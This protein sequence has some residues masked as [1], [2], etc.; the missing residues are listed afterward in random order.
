MKKQLLRNIVYLTLFLIFQASVTFSQTDFY[1]SRGE[2]VQ[3]T[4]SAEAVVIKFKEDITANEINTFLSAEDAI[5]D[6]N[7]LTLAGAK[8][9]F[10]ATLKSQTNLNQLS[11]R[12][13]G[14]TEVIALNNVYYIEGLEAVPYDQFMVQ[15]KSSVNRSQV[16][17][18]NKQ[19]DV[20][21]IE[22]NISVDHLYRLRVT[23][24]SDLSVVDMAK[25]YHESLPSE[26]STPDFIVP[27]QLY[28]PNDPYFSNQYYL[29]NTGQ[30][31]GVTDADIDALEAWNITIGSSS[32]TVAVIDEGGSSHPDLPASRLVAGYDYFY[33]DSD[34]SAGGN[35]AHSMASAGVVAGT[36][37]NS[38]GITGVA[39][40]SKVMHIRI[41]DECGNGASISNI[42]NSIDFAWQNGADIISNSW[43]Y[44]SSNPNFLP[45]IVDAINRALTMGR[46]DGDLIAEPSDK[47]C[48]VVFA[49]GNT[50][51]RGSLNYGYVSFPACVPG[52]LAVGAT[53]K[54]NNIQFYSPRD[55][56]LAVVAP[57][58][59]L[60]YYHNAVNLRKG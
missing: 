26:W 20:E 57:S 15:F 51:N 35:E 17:A 3:M 58:G 9:F 18:L 22:M 42:A 44:G 34:P 36:Q 52:V 49:A 46:G 6:M 11:E 12:L 10:K 1:Y 2:K 31:G 28:T 16:E 37:N 29:H 39:P 41:F 7:P 33:L 8:G 45:A 40:G 32:I 14:K 5:Q 24:K 27:I 38:E 13:K 43:G 23:E 48:V 4:V 47:G 19:H 55:N 53:D 60:G 54:S 50:A 25:L 56:E 21:I 59:D 30:T